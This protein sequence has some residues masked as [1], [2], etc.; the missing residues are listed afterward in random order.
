MF[1]TMK[2]AALALIAVLTISGC[3]THPGPKTSDLDKKRE[4]LAFVR[5]ELAIV[6]RGLESLQR[7]LAS[8]S[9]YP[10]EAQTRDLDYM[11][12]VLSQARDRLQAECRRM[13]KHYK[14]PHGPL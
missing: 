2:L 1:G 8:Q 3:A 9:A 11:T 13:E 6:M 14:V 7:K 4:E 12:S 5:E 10:I